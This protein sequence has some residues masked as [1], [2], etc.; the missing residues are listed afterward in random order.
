MSTPDPAPVAVLFVCSA[1]GCSTTLERRGYC[2]PCHR[3]WG[4]AHREHRRVYARS[5]RAGITPPK[6]KPNAARRTRGH[7]IRKG[8]RLEMLRAYGNACAQCGSTVLS[9]LVLVTTAHDGGPPAPHA[10]GAPFYAKLQAAGFP[11]SG[12]IGGRTHQISVRCKACTRWT[13]PKA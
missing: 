5:R 7:S 9:N 2:T 11:R 6:L 4:A 1:T 3:K 13:G 8:L 12:L 10:T